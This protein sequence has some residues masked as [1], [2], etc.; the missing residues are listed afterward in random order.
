MKEKVRFTKGLKYLFAAFLFAGLISCSKSSDDSSGA[1]NS[2]VSGRVTESS[3]LKSASLK[4]GQVAA[5]VQGA[6]VIIAE[7][8]ANGSLN[9]VSTQSVQT[10]VNGKFVVETK[11]SGT[12]NLVVVA[13][14][15]TSGWKAV[16]SAE[17]KSGTTVYA[18]PLNTETSAEAE[19][20]ARLIATGKTNVIS[21]TDVQLYVNAD[22]A[23]QIKGNASAQDQFISSLEVAAQAKTKASGNSYFGISSSQLQT[24]STANAQAQ[25]DFE[26]A[27]YN[28]DDSQSADEEKFDNFQKAIVSAYAS[29]NVKAETYAKLSV[30]SSEAFVN[31]AASMSLPIYFA[32]AE[33]NYLRV[34]F[35]MRQAME[36]KFMEA[37]ASSAQSSAVVSAGA[38]LTNSI[39]SSVSISQIADAFVQY[40][41]AVVAQL[42]L[43][44]SAQATAIGTIDTS[45]NG[46]VGANATLNVTI[47]ATVSADIIV[48]AYVNY[49]NSVKTL[50]QTSL[51]GASS[52]QIN[53]ASDILILANLNH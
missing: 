32:S 16:V 34:A 29:A 13:T 42:K 45:I 17:V 22:V 12:K 15:N 47:G 2:K 50:V 8:Q 25:A 46:I 6:T 9:T 4:S 43:T 24:I 7:V 5:G 51:S 38:N 40:H 10:D 53:A 44:L 39:K 30:I 35:I 14:K 36:A 28:A 41:S 33:S 52:T 48:N 31:A 27:L 21:Q 19:V 1:S 23:A 11:M 37:G 20:Y 3:G 18:Q 49:F 26:T